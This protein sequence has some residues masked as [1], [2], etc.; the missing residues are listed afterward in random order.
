MSLFAAAARSSHLVEFNAGKCIIEGRLIKPDTRKGMIY[1]EQGEDQLL[2]FYW[3][4]RQNESVPEDDWIIFPDEAE[5]T[6]V[7]QCTTGR[8]YLLRFKISNERHFYW[9]QNKSDEKDDELVERVN[10]LIRDP[11]TNMSPEPEDS[12]SHADFM[13]ILNNV[14]SQGMI[15]T[16][17]KKKKKISFTYFICLDPSLTPENILHFLR[18][19]NR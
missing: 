9:M 13:R 6:K 11:E 16:H 15:V 5:F 12:A 14:R 4:E 1:M 19:M 17:S 3:K 7:T 10:N 2:H 8:V 18:N